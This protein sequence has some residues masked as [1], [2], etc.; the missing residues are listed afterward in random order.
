[1][2]KC[3]LGSIGVAELPFEGKNVVL[4]SKPRAE[5]SLVRALK[6]EAALCMACAEE[7]T[8]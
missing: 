7:D 3:P 4:Y 6:G 5:T 2:A 1:M 8:T